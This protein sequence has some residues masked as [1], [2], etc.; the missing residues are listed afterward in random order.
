[1]YATGTV[2]AD[3][4]IS[5]LI[6]FTTGAIVNSQ[7]TRS[8]HLRHSENLNIS[9]CREDHHFLFTNVIVSPVANCKLLEQCQNK[10]KNFT[11]AIFHLYSEKQD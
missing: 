7:P 5:K 10:S 2:R 11:G 1:M 9:H 6:S 8:E 3:A 4:A